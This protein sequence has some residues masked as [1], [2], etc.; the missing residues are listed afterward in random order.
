MRTPGH[1]YMRCNTASA[2]SHHYSTLNRSVTD[3][4]YLHLAAFSTI[5]HMPLM[6]HVIH[7]VY[8]VDFNAVLLSQMKI[9]G[10]CQWSCG[11]ALSTHLQMLYV[12]GMPANA[13][14]WPNA[15]ARSS[16]SKAVMP[17]SGHSSNSNS[18]N[19]S[20]N[21]GTEADAPMP[22]TYMIARMSQSP[23]LFSGKYD[24]WG[25]GG[26]GASSSQQQHGG[27]ADADVGYRRTS[28]DAKASAS[29]H[30]SYECVVCCVRV[31]TLFSWLA[32]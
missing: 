25:G 24:T 28:L 20:S 22:Q 3:V 26:G 32:Y 17:T 9:D 18:K 5:R 19:S 8:N 23:A 13:S 21:G 7:A 2:L 15:A 30:C 10:L 29:V 4:Y 11:D 14:S 31:L 27:D 6:S 16:S 12:A 1:A